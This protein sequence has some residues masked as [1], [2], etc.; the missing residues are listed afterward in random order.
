MA[1]PELYHYGRKGY[2]F[3]QK[4]FVVYMFDALVQVSASSFNF[5]YS[6]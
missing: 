6:I 2:W 4:S 5:I 3:N 1:V